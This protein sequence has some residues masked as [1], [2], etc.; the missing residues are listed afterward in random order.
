M[1]AFSIIII[2]LFLSC[3]TAAQRIA[4]HVISTSGA[5][6]SNGG[7]KVHFIVGEI[8]VKTISNGS[9]SI[10]PGF[11]SSNSSSSAGNLTAV[12]DKE[13]IK[14]VT[15]YPNPS[16]DLFFVE[17]NAKRAMMFSL[18]VSDM[19]G[20]EMNRLIYAVNNNHITI[21]AKNWPS[22]V[23]FISVID[24]KGN[25]IYSFKVVRQ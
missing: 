20:L 11:T 9:G 3:V 14:H 8:T 19:N 15:V 13:E 22:G 21:N 7:L 4:P 18:M 17:I 23:Y 16:S 12:Q 5:T 6:I 10:A 2:P 1:K 25:V 24:K